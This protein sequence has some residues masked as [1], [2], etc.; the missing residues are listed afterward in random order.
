MQGTR[1]IVMV[2]FVKVFI[3]AKDQRLAVLTD[4]DALG[5]GPRQAVEQDQVWT[6]CKGQP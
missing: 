2:D 4:L 6:T 3:Q 1:D 5:H